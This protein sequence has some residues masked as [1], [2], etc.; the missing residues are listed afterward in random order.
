MKT[1]LRNFI[2]G[3]MVMGIA[4][5][6]EMTPASSAERVHGTVTTAKE[7]KNWIDGKTVRV[8]DLRSK[9]D[10]KAGHIPGAVVMKNKE[11]EDPNNPVDGELAPAK[12][13]EDLMI[14]KG[15]GSDDHVVVYG[16]GSSPQMATRLWWAFKVYGHK[17]VQVLDGHYQSWV[18]AG[19]PIETG[20]GIKASPSTYK[21][22]TFD[23]SRIATLKDCINPSKQTV[24]LDVRPLAEYTGEKVADKAG[25]GGHIPGALNVYYMNTVDDKGFF[26]DVQVLKAMYAGVGVTPDKDVIVYCMRGHRASHT[27]F[28]LT[29]LLGFRN[30]RLYDGSWI[31]WSNSADLPVATGTAR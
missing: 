22:V 18:A 2:A 25:R 8:I 12:Q 15:I 5:F 13:F 10:Y 3:V 11:F 16:S 28:V 27:Y 9:E 24:L 1:T 7:L 19:Y 14:S 21:T 26:K 29:N 17:D 6:V 30:V 23:K 31:E 4:A 20:T